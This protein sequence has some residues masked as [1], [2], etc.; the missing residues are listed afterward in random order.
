MSSGSKLK[1]AILKKRAAMSVLNPN[2]KRREASK[3][4]KIGTQY[5]G[6]E[7]KEEQEEQEEDKENDG[8]EEE[9]KKNNESDQEAE[10]QQL[11]ARRADE[12]ARQFLAGSGI[13][14][15]SE[16]A[17]AKQRKRILTNVERAVRKARTEGCGKSPFHAERGCPG[18]FR[19]EVFFDGASVQFAHHAET[20]RQKQAAAT[21][22]CR[23]CFLVNAVATRN[24][25]TEI[26]KEMLATGCF[27]WAVC[28]AVESRQQRRKSSL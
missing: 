15:K 3:G 11:I 6:E 1:Q 2:A 24:Q 27:K 16:E 22:K 28:H 8:G 19:P 17:K 10:W 7:E 26:F 14:L 23:E 13:R 25:S 18:P 9:S 12:L 21:G 4:I 20:S 5:R